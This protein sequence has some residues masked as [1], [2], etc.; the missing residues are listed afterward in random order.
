MSPS[1]F[2]AKIDTC[3]MLLGGQTADLA[4][5]DKFLYALRDVTGTVPSIPLIASS[6][7]SKK[8][9][10]GADAIVLDVTCGNGAFMKDVE[11]ARELARRM[12]AIGKLAGKPVCCVMSSM[13]Q[14][15]GHMVG[16]V[17]EMMEV[18]EVLSGKGPDD[19]KEVVLTMASEMLKMTD[20][21]KGK[22]SEELKSRCLE[23][24]KNGEAFNKFGD[25]ILS[26]GGKLH[27]DGT[28]VF[29]D[30]PFEV[31]TVHAEKD[32]YVEICDALE[33]GEASC[34]LGAGR[35]KKEDSID[36]GAGIKLHK[37]IGDKVS[38]GEELY[39]LYTGT[40]SPVSEDRIDE[41]LLKM[42]KAKN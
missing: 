40:H 14:P 1:E 2:K 17:L 34:L 24:L 8:I 20:A 4:P 26:Q 39:T 19:V 15:L 42:G 21:G 41:A 7:M 5:A 35:M 13:V 37:K 25:L 31:M 22:S 11:S 6:I 29:V 38:R 9:A 36:M 16:N 32:G 12:I 10:G 27:S 23:K 28:P 30:Q 33:V 18:V 3:G